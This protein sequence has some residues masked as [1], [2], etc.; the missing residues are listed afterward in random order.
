M[1]DRNLV[2]ALLEQAET[3]LTTAEQ[4]IK[5]SLDQLA[6]A[7]MILQEPEAPPAPDP[8]GLGTFIPIDPTRVLKLEKNWTFGTNGNVRN[9]D[10]LARE[11][12]GYD[13]FGSPVIGTTEY[14]T[15]TT[16]TDPNDRKPITAF[17]LPD[18]S[19]RQPIEPG[20]NAP[21]REFT[22]DSML[23]HVRSLRSVPQTVS[24][25]TYPAGSIG[26]SWT[27]SGQNGNLY[28][29]FSLPAAGNIADIDVVWQTH[30][31]MRTAPEGYWFALWVYGKPW[32]RGAE[33][34]IVES[35][36]GSADS[37][38]REGRAW[39]S[40]SV[41]GTD[42]R[43]KSNES[44]WRGLEKTGFDLS[45][46]EQALTNWLTWTLYYRRDN[47]FEVYANDKLVQRGVIYWR[48]SGFPEGQPTPMHFALDFSA[49]HTAIGP[50]NQV[51]IPP[52]TTI[53][54]ELA[55]SRI[56]TR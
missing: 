21:V 13:A 31:R 12:D 40:Q 47:T 22:T 56:W 25:R 20:G 24:G 3:Q 44:W 36:S 17:S 1:S 2:D 30:V 53:T 19:H 5:D 45:K 43:F 15:V 37:G 32:V 11:F 42:E 38:L 26:P 33:I 54:Y 39:H 41:G 55:W 50:I 34:D 7:R 8:V 48:Q 46:G 23:A 14:G 35:Y 29:K 10:D 16:A 49:L 6:A 52:G 51:V 18:G 28:P 9:Y 4:A 27:W